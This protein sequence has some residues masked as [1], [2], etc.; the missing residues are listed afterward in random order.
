MDTPNHE[1]DYTAKVAELVIE[2][3]K[4]AEAK[5]ELVKKLTDN[6]VSHA[7]TLLP[8]FMARRTKIPPRMRKKALAKLREMMPAAVFDR[9]L[10]Q[11]KRR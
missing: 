3:F 7:A 8:Y 10:E 4:N 9:L 6:V 2:G 5:H 1:I 11:N